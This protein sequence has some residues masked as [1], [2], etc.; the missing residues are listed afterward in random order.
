LPRLV[1]ALDFERMAGRASGETLVRDKSF[2]DDRALLPSQR[3]AL[4]NNSSYSGMRSTSFW[5]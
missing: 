2:H 5:F 4:E 1:P 3:R